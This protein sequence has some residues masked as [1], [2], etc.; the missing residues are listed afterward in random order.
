MV[1]T[2]ISPAAVARVVGIETE[3]V[4][5]RGGIAFL[6]Q[7]IAVV[8]QGSTASTYPLEKTRVFSEAEAGRVYGYG[9]PIHLAVRELLPPIGEGVGV[10][11][12]HIL[13]LEDDESGVA[14]EGS[15]VPDDTTLPASEAESYRVVVAGIESEQF[16]IDE[17]DDLSS[18]VTKMAEAINAVLS[19]PVTA[20]ANTTS[21]SEAVELEAKWAGESG[22]AIT[23]SVSGGDAVEFTITD[24]TGGLVNPSVQPALDMI[25]ESN[26]ITWIVNCLNY[27]D[28]DALDA[29]DTFGESRWDPLVKK[30]LAAAV[31]G[32]SETSVATA[33][34]VSE[35]R[36]T[37]RTNA[38]VNVE[39]SPMYPAAIA[40][41][42]VARAAVLA[43]NNPPHDYGSQPMRRIT[44]G[45]ESEE[46]SYTE[47]DAAV[48]GGVSTTEIKDG[49]VNLS[50][51]VTHYAPEGEVPPAYRY[52]VD[53]V[54]NQ[55]VIFNYDLEF[56]TPK[57]DGAP[58]VPDGQATTNP[59]A[60]K[61]STAKAAIAQILD[62]LG[63]N[64]IISDPDTAKENTQAQI[65]SQN[66]KRLNVKSTIQLAG[67][68]NIRSITN[69]FGFFFG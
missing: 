8:G 22:N 10:V 27:D 69:E 46:W 60:K 53:T 40:G 15:I 9:S 29:L 48:K 3:F 19:M 16:V 54:K 33:I 28:T 56:N 66:P 61:P 52:V 64:A 14:A 51:L 57:W 47:R 7:Q 13:P 65:D 12:V 38:Q 23:L 20:T 43:N 41:A 59:D 68:S 49:T 17:G 39:G 32:S 25:G 30:P 45:A 37:D 63:S 58:L 55:Q 1:S 35:T 11:P 67:N 6:P 18:A 24:M 21:G 31:R 42:A 36:T 34:S 50:D 2:A 44:R 4:N 62:S 5:L 26:W